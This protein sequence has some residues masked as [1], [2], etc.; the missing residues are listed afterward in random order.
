MS[1]YLYQDKQEIQN[2]L[3]ALPLEK[4]KELL[5]YKQSFSSLF[6]MVLAAIIAENS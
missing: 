4:L 5:E 6:Q 3:E 1:S 2:Y